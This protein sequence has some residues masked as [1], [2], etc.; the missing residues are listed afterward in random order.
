MRIFVVRDGRGEVDDGHSPHVR[1]GRAANGVSV[2]FPSKKELTRRSSLTERVGRAAV[3]G[4]AAGRQQ[5][6]RL[7]LE[8]G[9]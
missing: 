8:P 3:A 5:K 7:L 9:F 1:G 6:S 2:F 4:G